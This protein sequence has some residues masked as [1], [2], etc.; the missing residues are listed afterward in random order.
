MNK[1][2]FNRA[3]KLLREAN[4]AITHELAATGYPEWKNNP[5]LASKG[6]L[7]D[8]IAKFLERLAKGGE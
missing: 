6:K 7:C 4:D 2:Q 8:R 1:R 3:I 5:V